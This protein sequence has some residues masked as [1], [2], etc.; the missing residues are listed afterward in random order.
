[1]DT[2]SCVVELPLDRCSRDK[3]LSA[4]QS[5]DTEPRGSRAASF[6]EFTLVEKVKQLLGERCAFIIVKQYNLITGGKILGGYA[7]KLKP[8]PAQHLE[9]GVGWNLAGR[10][11]GKT[12]A[13]V[14]RLA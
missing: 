1:M 14:E 2:Y 5:D 8:F 7:L 4:D 13:H 9:S 11:I 3:G 6:E 10:A 12:N